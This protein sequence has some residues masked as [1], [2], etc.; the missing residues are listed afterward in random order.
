MLVLGVDGGGG[1]SGYGVFLV[2]G[3]WISVVWI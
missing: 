3:G 1:E 2:D